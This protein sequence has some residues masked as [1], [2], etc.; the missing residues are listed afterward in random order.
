MDRCHFSSDTVNR[1][2]LRGAKSERS[3][4]SRCSLANATKPIQGTQRSSVETVLGTLGFDADLLQHDLRI[5]MDG[6]STSA[7]SKG[8][9]FRLV[10]RHDLT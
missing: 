9:R 6:N 1:T 4:S 5:E 10:H 2:D 3:T 7:F 8:R